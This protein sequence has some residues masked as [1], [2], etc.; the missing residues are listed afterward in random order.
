MKE[1]SYAQICSHHRGKPGISRVCASASARGYN[2]LLVARRADR[3][4][5]LSDQLTTEYEIQRPPTSE[6]SECLRLV[7][8]PDDRRVD[9]VH[10]ST[11]ALGDCGPFCRPILDRDFD[12][13]AVN[14]P[15]GITS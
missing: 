9:S 12:M 1:V 2:L 13:L 5:K 8:A 15:R 3:L 10:Q 14:I 11:Q 7:K 4:E 6:E